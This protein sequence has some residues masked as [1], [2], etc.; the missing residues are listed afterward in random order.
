VASAEVISPFVGLDPVGYT[1]ANSPCIRY[2]GNVPRF[3]TD[4]RN[5]ADTVTRDHLLRVYSEQGQWAKLGRSGGREPKGGADMKI[6]STQPAR[7]C[8]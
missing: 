7:R 8:C 3:F 6:A 2:L 1:I 5:P 4:K